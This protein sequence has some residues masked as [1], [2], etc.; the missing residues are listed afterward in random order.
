MT[1][2]LS[3]GVL[4]LLFSATLAAQVAVVNGASFRNDQPVAAGAIASAFG[5]FGII[6]AT[7]A[8]SLPLPTTLAGVKVTVGTTD[9]P[10]FF[11]SSGQVN[12]QVP[13]NLAAGRYDVT[14]T[15]AAGSQKSSILLSTVAPG[16]FVDASA[17]E[18]PAR[19][20]I[21]NQNSSP[22]TPANPAKRGEVLIIYATGQGATSAAVASGTAA[23]SS[24][25]VNSA[26]API[27]YIAG[28]PATVDFSGLAPGFVGL[29]QINVRVPNQS[30]ISGRVPVRVFIN[31]VDSNE[32]GAF[33]AQ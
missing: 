11:V 8:P 13:A 7:Q 2:K 15:S 18:T 9:A 12:F 30:F 29:W 17:K 32:V 3:A 10:L 4:A 20:A 5:S 27:V 25:V 16:L 19:G 23:P 24:P 31:G 6:S 26:S 33:V 1:K 14:V 28:V 22:N 21:Q